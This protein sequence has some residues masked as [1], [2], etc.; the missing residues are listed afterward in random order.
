MPES[1]ANKGKNSIGESQQKSSRECCRNEQNEREISLVITTLEVWI[2]LIKIVAVLIIKMWGVLLT[3]DEIDAEA[4]EMEDIDEVNIV[5]IPVTTEQYFE[6]VTSDEM[7]R[8][9]T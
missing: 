7:K 9:E 8:I 2:L 3:M 1:I 4:L 6:S 5:A